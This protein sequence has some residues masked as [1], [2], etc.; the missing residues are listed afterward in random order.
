[1]SGIWGSGVFYW[2][3]S[4]LKVKASGRPGERGG[5]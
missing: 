4:S 5:E 1:M 3:L 2:P